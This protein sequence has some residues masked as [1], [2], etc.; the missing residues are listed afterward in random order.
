MVF[1]TRRRYTSKALRK[2][3]FIDET[4]RSAEY[5]SMFRLAA[6]TDWIS[7][8]SASFAA[9]VAGVSLIRQEKTA[10]AEGGAT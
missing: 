4:G 10:S 1:K 6:I 5:E 8:I 2:R 7:A 9:A 3:R